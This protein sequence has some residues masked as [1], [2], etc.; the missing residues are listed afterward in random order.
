[1]KSVNSPNQ[2]Q[3]DFFRTNRPIH[4]RLDPISSHAPF[5]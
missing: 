2:C 3:H 4:P 5:C 1:V